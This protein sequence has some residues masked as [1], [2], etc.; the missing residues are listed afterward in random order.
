MANNE[1][2]R[3]LDEATGILT[4]ATIKLESGSEDISNKISVNFRYE[5]YIG[6]TLTIKNAAGILYS[7]KCFDKT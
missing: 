3:A 6:V 4:T 5:S 2:K 7:E 1:L